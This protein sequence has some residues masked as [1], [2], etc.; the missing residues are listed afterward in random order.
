[1]QLH[2]ACPFLVN[3]HP[4]A[5]HILHTS[6]VLIGSSMSLFTLDSGE[7]VETPAEDEYYEKQVGA[8]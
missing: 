7:D 2:I 8:Q 6:F 3:T 5:L 1:M 4:H